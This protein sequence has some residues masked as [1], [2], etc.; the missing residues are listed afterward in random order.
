MV[1][2]NFFNFSFHFPGSKQKADEAKKDWVKSLLDDGGYR[3]FN[4]YTVERHIDGD[5]VADYFE[6]D[7]REQIYDDPDNYDIV[8]DL[9]RDQKNELWVLKMEK[10]VYE[11]EG[12]R[13]PIKYPT[14]EE[15]GT[16]F[17]FWD[18]D[19]EHE[20]QLRYEGNRWVLYKDGSVTQPG[21]LYDDEDTQDHQDDRESRISDIEYEMQEIEENPD[22]DLDE[23]SIEDAVETKKYD[24]AQDPI[25]WLRDYDMDVDNFIDEKAFIEDVAD[26]EDYG[27][28]NG[29][30]ST[31]DIINLGNQSYVVMITDK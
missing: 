28:L 27:I 30:D 25:R 2:L 4:Q 29:Y 13:F 11:N 8:R 14:K 12:V 16:I 5:E 19:E 31:Y 6:D 17:D 24:I 10:W 23:D 1:K 18:E 20:F 9:S 22:G 3:H 21:Q 15:N 7:I 26:D